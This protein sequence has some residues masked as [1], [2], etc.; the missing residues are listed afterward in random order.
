VT[1]ASELRGRMDEASEASALSRP[2]A[3]S[4][5]RS[6][7][8]IRI[9]YCVSTL[10]TGGSE[11]NAIR[12]AERLRGEFEFTIIHHQGG[13][14]SQRCEAAGMDMV[15]FPLRNL[16]GADAVRQGVAFARL[17]RKRRF[18]VVHSHD[19]YMNMFV[20]PWAAITGVPFIASRRWWHDRRDRRKYW[21]PNVVAYRLAKRVLANSDAVAR[22]LF[23]HDRVRH[24]RIVVVPNFVE[25]GAFRRLGEPEARAIRSE[26]N[27]P[28]EALV[29]G[30]IARLEPVKDHAT[31]LRAIARLRP[32]WP[33][34]RLVVVGG[35]SRAPALEALA[36]SLGIR[37]AS[38]FLGER[39][40]EPNLHH[41]FDISVLCSTSEAFPNTIVEAMAAGR[42]VVAT[43]VG[44][45]PDAVQ[46]DVT[47]LLANPGDDE[48]LACAIESLLLDPARRRELG[49][50]GQRRA[51][52]VYHADT[53]LPRL[54]ALYRD[55]MRQGPRAA[56]R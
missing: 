54:A 44:A 20:A 4:P 46:A 50:N 13:P 6:E 7:R 55:A 19:I 15:R 17:L 45:I 8:P 23:E 53:V 3:S 21:L 42:A 22:S 9:A 43:N 40:H 26:W 30:I 25:E 51:R 36:T 27:L 28:A 29:V 5:E 34:L 39:A 38:L 11:L 14:L 41:L 48:R 18:D 12:C 47:G 33:S 16:Y 31:L 49:A 2:R 1:A 24:D 32:R 35:G 52:A 37:D 56:R 10:Q